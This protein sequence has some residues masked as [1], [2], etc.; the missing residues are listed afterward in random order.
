MAGAWQTLTWTTLLGL[1]TSVAPQ[2]AA[3]TL[4][5]VGAPFDTTSAS[6]ASATQR[7]SSKPE[8]RKDAAAAQKELEAGIASLEAGK[9]D[10]A[11]RRF[12]GVLSGG[13]LPSGLMAKALYHRG[14]AFRRLGKPVQAISD[15]T[16]ALWLK[17]GLDE[18]DRA[19]AL[20]MRAAAYRDAG[21]PDQ[22]DAEQKQAGRVAGGPS[23]G[24][25]TAPSRMHNGASEAAA[26]SAEPP[27]A[28][29]AAPASGGGLGRFFGD[30]F[31][32]TSS[33]PAVQT[34]AVAASPSRSPSSGWVDFGGW[35]DGTEVR[36][37]EQ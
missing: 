26:A 5:D 16:S 6:G 22:V 21:L 8:A 17:N 1:G 36:R 18:S 3:Q 14:V 12:T 35:V 7:T 10:S 37:S 13:S 30:L 24:G 25:M 34:G 32:R 29:A 33:G 11:V 9:T 19:D 20:A 28:T 23:T 15:L 31:G 2:V 4:G 27:E